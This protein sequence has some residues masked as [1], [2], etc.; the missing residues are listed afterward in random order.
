MANKIIDQV[1]SNAENNPSYFSNWWRI[2]STFK[3]NP[4]IFIKSVNAGNELNELKALYPNDSSRIILLNKNDYDSSESYVVCQG[5]HCFA[6]VFSISELNHLL[7]EI[8]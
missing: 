8:I 2:I 7:N 6:P 5:D 1:V 4:K 3:W